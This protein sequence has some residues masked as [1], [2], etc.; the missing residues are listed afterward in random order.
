MF[1][2]GS[3]VTRQRRKPVPDPYDPTHLV[4]GSW[5]DPDEAGIEDAWVASSTATAVPDASRTQSTAYKSLYCP[6]DADVL[7]GDRIVDGAH[8]YQVQAVPAADV[9]PFTGWQPVMEVPLV[10]VSG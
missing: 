3:T 10:E 5:D 9:N 2:F 4:P 1:G 8:T 6:P 7:K